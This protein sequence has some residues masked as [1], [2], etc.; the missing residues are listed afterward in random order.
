[1]KQVDAYLNIPLQNKYP[2]TF[3]HLIKQELLQKQGK[4]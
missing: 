2:I 4:I 1:M 3:D